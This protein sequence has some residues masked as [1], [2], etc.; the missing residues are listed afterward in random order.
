MSNSEYLFL[1][2]MLTVFILGFL[3][4]LNA[5]YFQIKYQKRVDQTLD[6]ENY[7]DG[8]GIF[9]ASRMMIHAHYCLFQKRAERDGVIK[10]MS[11]IPLVVK[12]HLIFHWLAV[13]VMC[14][15]AAVAFVVHRT[16]LS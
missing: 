3:M 6:G 4:L 7:I 5:I 14:L 12:M 9:N 15:L 1:A 16:M 2:L 13:I 10:Q 8:G 11:L